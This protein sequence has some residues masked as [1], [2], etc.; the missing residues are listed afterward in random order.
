ML[1][2]SCLFKARVQNNKITVLLK[3]GR[4]LISQVE[5][6]PKVLTTGVATPLNF[7]SLIN[8]ET[9]VKEEL[10]RVTC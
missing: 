5:H 7:H 8:M 6:F 2:V 3:S 4:G 9:C 1:R 10:F